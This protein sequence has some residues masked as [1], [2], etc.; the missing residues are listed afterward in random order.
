MLEP[1]RAAFW[2]G[3]TVVAVVLGLR[4]SNALQPIELFAYDLLLSRLDRPEQPSPRVALIEISERDIQDL[5]HWPLS[6]R[7]VARLIESI[8][9]AGATHVGLD[10]YRDLPVA[11]GEGRLEAL[12]ESESRVVLVFKHGDPGAGGIPGRASLEGSGRLGFSDLLLD[13]DGRVRR[14]LL[15]LERADGGT[16]YAFALQLALGRLAREGIHPQ[17]DPERPEWIRLGETTIP[18]LEAGNGG[19]ADIDDQGYQMLHD[20]ARSRGGFEA[21]PFRAALDGALGSES[22]ADRIVLVGASAESLNDFALVPRGIATHAMTERGVTGV[23]LHALLL[24]QLLRIAYGEARPLR[25]L[26]NAV[27]IAMVLIAAMIG[28]GLSVWVAHR[29]ALVAPRLAAVVIGACVAGGCIGYASLASGVWT[30]VVGPAIAWIGAAVGHTAW[31]SGRDRAQRAELMQIFSHVQSPRVAQEMWRRRDEYLKEGRLEPEEATVTV[32]FLDMKGYTASAERLAPAVLMGWIN[33]LMSPMARLIE[34]H[35][36]YPDDY[37]GDGIKADFG[38]PILC[39]TDEEVVET[40]RNALRCAQA[41]TQELERINARY[42]EAGLPT[43]GLRIGVHTGPVVVGLLG[44]RNK[45]KYTVVGDAVVTAQRLEATDQVAHDFAAQPCRILMSAET[46][47]LLAGEPVGD[48]ESIGSI[49]L[50]GKETPTS[51]YRLNT[52][53]LRAA[54]AV[55]SA[56]CS[57]H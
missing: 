37:F 20:F 23:W 9:D 36:G 56:I 35:G 19:Y 8:L 16:D 40:A 3:S 22:L 50:K 17:P 44:S 42:A 51:V 55:T 27:E 12:L 2:I 30:P 49:S 1:L 34:E 13:P 54:P 11:P 32:L 4:A 38:V 10:M 29:S 39:E 28:Y 7:E 15:F 57:S 25:F 21:V 14:A 48:Y 46:H 6:D 5:G 53:S 26:S 41:M 18:Y 45:A 24:D 47:A 43:V 33:D 31:I 52:R